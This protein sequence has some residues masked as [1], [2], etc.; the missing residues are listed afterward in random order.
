MRQSV[1]PKFRFTKELDDESYISLAVW[2]GNEDPKDEVLSVTLREIR[3]GKT[4]ARLAVYRSKNGA[5]SQLPVFPGD[6]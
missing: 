2:S 3:E 1:R 5:Y 6:G 4:K